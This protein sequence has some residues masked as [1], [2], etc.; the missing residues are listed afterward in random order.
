MSIVRQLTGEAEL[1]RIQGTKMTSYFSTVSTRVVLTD[2]RVY[3]E[4]GDTGQ[5]ESRIIPLRSVDSFGLVTSSKTW[6]LVLGVLLA[7]YGFFSLV[8]SNEKG[9]AFFTVLIGGA[10]IAAWW[11][12][13]KIG[14]I[15]HSCSGKTEIFVEASASNQEDIANFIAHIQEAVDR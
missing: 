3:Q 9:G 6:L 4:S 11:H 1:A 14:A 15:V 5:Q 2:K 8:S 13:R 7:L 12:T 10:F